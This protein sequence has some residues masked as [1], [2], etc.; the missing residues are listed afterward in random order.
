MIRRQ[1]KDIGSEHSTRRRKQLS[2]TTELL[3]P[4]VAPK[5]VP[6]SSTPTCLLAPPSLPSSLPTKT[7]LL[8]FKPISSTKP[9]LIT[10]T[11]TSFSDKN[12]NNS[13]KSLICRL[14]MGGPVPGRILLPGHISPSLVLRNHNIN[15][16]ISTQEKNVSYHLC[17]LTC[18]L[19]TGRR[20]PSFGTIRA[21]L[22]SLLKRIMGWASSRARD[23]A[24]LLMGLIRVTNFKMGPLMISLLHLL[25][26]LFSIDLY[27]Y[28]VMWTSVLSVLCLV[29]LLQ[30]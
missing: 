17:H 24:R 19:L 12:N 2:L 18:R 5:P 3:A 28:V 1:R 22:A 7:S 21:F 29:C 15:Y 6:T 25:L 23:R 10:T 20:L 9:T 8:F 13:H 27:I 4:C 30:L 14:K 11:I 16:K 26:R